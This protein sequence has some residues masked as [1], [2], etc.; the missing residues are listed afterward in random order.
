MEGQGLCISS[1]LQTENVVQMSLELQTPRKYVG[2][3]VIKALTMKK[4]GRSPATFLLS[5]YRTA[6]RYIPKDS[7]LQGVNK[8]QDSRLPNSAYLCNPET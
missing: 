7:I 4:S 8:M 3:W 5:F 2:F 1:L 6:R